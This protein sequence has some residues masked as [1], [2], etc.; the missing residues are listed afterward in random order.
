MVDGIDGGGFIHAHMNATAL[1]PRRSIY[2]AANH[3]IGAGTINRTVNLADAADEILESLAKRTG[4]TISEFVREALADGMERVDSK[5][6]EQF[7]TA[8]HRHARKAAMFFFIV[9]I[10]ALSI[11][12]FQIEA[13][14]PRRAGMASRIQAHPARHPQISA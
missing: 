4:K 9:S 11:S 5:A 8:I 14:R 1:T 3:Q 10:P 2:K 13:R 12:G 7:R 6:A